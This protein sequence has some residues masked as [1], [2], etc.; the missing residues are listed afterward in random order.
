MMQQQLAQHQASLLHQ[1]W[2]QQAQAHF[3]AA[4]AATASTVPAAGSLPSSVRQLPP[5]P[6]IQH[7][8]HDCH[9]LR[10]NIQQPGLPKAGPAAAPDAHHSPHVMAPRHG[11]QHAPVAAGAAAVAVP[12]VRL[13]MATPVAALPAPRVV[14]P[15][16]VTDPL[17]FTLVL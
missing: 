11:G 5:P 12:V 1:A 17:A 16:V 13:T 4:A 7:P 8:F 14:Q 3:N 9:S 10:T 15:L 6:G 2:L